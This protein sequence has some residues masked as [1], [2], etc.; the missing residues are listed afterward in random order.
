MFE[1]EKKEKRRSNTH[2]GMMKD[3]GRT[4]NGAV[5]SSPELHSHPSGFDGFRL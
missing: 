2:G 4:R 5:G 1:G 3:T